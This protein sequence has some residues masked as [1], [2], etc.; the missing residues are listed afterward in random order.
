MEDRQTGKMK[1]RNGRNQ[2]T[3]ERWDEGKL[4]PFSHER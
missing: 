1:R 2:M 3:L 4:Q